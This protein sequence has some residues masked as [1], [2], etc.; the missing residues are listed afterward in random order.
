[1]ISAARVLRRSIEAASASSNDSFIDERQEKDDETQWKTVRHPC[2]ARQ[3][4]ASGRD[5]PSKPAYLNN[6]P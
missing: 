2:T 3:R 1:M 5:S 6:L 4:Y